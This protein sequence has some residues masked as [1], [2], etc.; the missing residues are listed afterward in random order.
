MNVPAINRRH[1]YQ[2]RRCLLCGPHK[3]YTEGF[4]RYQ[5]REWNRVYQLLSAE[6]PFRVITILDP[7]Y[8]NCALLI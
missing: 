4:K 3:T 6:C 2:L 8:T 5:S 1:H 7:R